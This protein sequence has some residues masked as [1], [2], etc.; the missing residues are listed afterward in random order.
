M[1][2]LLAV[3]LV[4]SLV[5]LSQEIDFLKGLGLGKILGGYFKGQRSEIVSSSFDRDQKKSQNCHRVPVKQCKDVPETVYERVEEEKC[6]K[7]P[8]EECS[9]EAV[10]EYR[11][12]ARQQCE[13][14]TETKCQDVQDRQCHNVK[15]PVQVW[16]NH[17]LVTDYHSC[18]FQETEYKQECR[19]EYTQSCNTVYDTR[20]QCSTKYEEV[21]NTVPETKCQ[22][23]QKPVQVGPG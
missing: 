14:I 16:S 9:E 15:K 23:V 4:I 7:R 6:E 18:L 10:T 17:L 12:V 20:Q 21:C 22:D 11:E 19:T 3:C 5:G 13:D 8:V 1:R 2:F